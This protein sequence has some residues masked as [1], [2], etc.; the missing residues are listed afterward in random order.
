MVEAQI[1]ILPIQLPLL[2]DQLIESRL[3]NDAQDLALVTHG[4]HD[5]QD[6]LNFRR[7]LPFTFIV[8]HAKRLIQRAIRMR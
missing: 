5:I 7:T 2:H 1:R 6:L 3:R 4:V 8:V